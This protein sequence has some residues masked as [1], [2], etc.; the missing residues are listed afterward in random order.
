MDL[1]SSFPGSSLLLCGKETIGMGWKHGE[2]QG[3]CNP[4]EKRE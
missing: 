3:S 4:G 2:L 1:T